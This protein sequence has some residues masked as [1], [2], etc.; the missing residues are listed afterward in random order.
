VA[1]RLPHNQPDRGETLQDGLITSPN[2]LD[3]AVRDLRGFPG[4]LVR[5]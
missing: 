3:K 4:L 1:N 2:R 5:S